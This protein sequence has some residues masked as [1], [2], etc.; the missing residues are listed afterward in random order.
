MKL[1]SSITIDLTGHP[2][3]DKLAD[4]K[5]RLGNR[6]HRTIQFPAPYAVYAMQGHGRNINRTSKF[7]NQADL[8]RDFDDHYT[9]PKNFDIP[10]A[11]H[12]ATRQ[13]LH[14]MRAWDLDAPGPRPPQRNPHQRRLRRITGRLADTAYIPRAPKI[15]EPSPNRQPFTKEKRRQVKR[16]YQRRTSGRIR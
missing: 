5:V 15:I 1:R 8:K 13:M 9:R 12:Y 14:R 7:Y 6:F 11:L 10:R 2:L 16:A 3:Y 4:A